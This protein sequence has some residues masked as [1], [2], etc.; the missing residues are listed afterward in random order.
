M[1]GVARFRYRRARISF[2]Q[3]NLNCVERLHTRRLGEIDRCKR[4]ERFLLYVARRRE[5]DC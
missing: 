1:A 4:V 2:V 5:G 3:L